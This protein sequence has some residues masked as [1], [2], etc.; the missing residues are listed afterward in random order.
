MPV[1]DHEAAPGADA[2][3]SDIDPKVE[4]TAC[5]ARIASALEIAASEQA[6][7]R[8][9]CIADTTEAFG[10]AAEAVLPQLARAGFAALIAEATQAIARRGQWPELLVTVAPEDAAAVTDALASP[11][12]G[13]NL[14]PKPGPELKITEDPALGP[15]EAHL[16]WSQ[17]GA[18]I[19]VEAIAETA[20][21]TSQ[22]GKY[23]RAIFSVPVDVVVSVGHAR[24]AIGELLAMRRDMVLP[25]SSRMDDPVEILVGDRVI[26]RGEL[27]ELG[28]DAGRLGV[29]LTEVVDVSD[30]F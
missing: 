4:R 19:D 30:L 13:L 28:D 8:A 9:R 3:E 16:G 15:G 26:A 21:N 29:R 6:A 1:P 12:N 2:L 27:E 14:C 10:K 18:E 25:L 11:D 17:G 7:L 22:D 20:R 23:R 5:L 24:P